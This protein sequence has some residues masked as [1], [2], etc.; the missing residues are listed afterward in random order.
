MRHVELPN[1]VSEGTLRRA[2]DAAPDAI[3]IVDDSGIISF[4]NNMAEVMFGYLSTELVGLAV[5]K[6][7]PDAH[8]DAH[9]A[10]RSGYIA[11]PR[12]RAMGSGLDLRCRHRSGEEFPVEISLSPLE[13]TQ[14][15][16]VIA[17]V[18]DLTERHRLGTELMRANEDLALADDRERIARDL[19][20]TVIQRLFAIG[21]SL[22][23]ALA[24]A[25]DPKTTDRVERAI[26]EIDGSIRDIRSAIF[27]LH[28]RQLPTSGPREDVVAMAREAG[29]ALGFEPSV[30]FDGLID[31]VMTP[32]LHENLLPTLREALSNITKHAQATRAW[33]HVEIV[34]GE[35]R[36]RVAD[37][38]VGVRQPVNGGLGIVSL[39]E[40]AVGLG[41]SCSISANGDRGTVVDWRVPLPRPG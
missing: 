31:T 34:D 33:V 37:N 9:V 24:F 38:G 18:R 25:V 14:H 2:V 35:L 12:T 16:Y 10:T 4:A 8:R 39:T 11:A 6:L 30:T 5:E 20:D 41:G 32:E 26:D 36:L 1:T 15:K 19:H 21:L 7:V 28:A 22:Q 17:V 23:S 13:G 40:R 3:L 27:S 29:R